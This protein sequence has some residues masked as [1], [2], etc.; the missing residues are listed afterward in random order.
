MGRL[1]ARDIAVKKHRGERIVALTAYDAPTARA[2]ESAGIDLILVGDSVGNVVLGMRD[3]R[4]V[5]LDMTIHHTAAVVRGTKTA[6]VCADLPFGSYQ[7]SPEEAKR[8]VVRVVAETGCQSVKLEGGYPWLETIR[9]IVAMGVPVLGHLGHTPQS[10]SLAALQPDRREWTEEETEALVAE[11]RALESAGCFALVL[12]V[13]PRGAARRVT[14]ALRIP[15][16][17]IGAGPHC[18]GQILVVNDILGI[19]P[20]LPHA[21]R[22]AELGEAMERA[23]REY[24]GEVRDGSFPGPEHGFG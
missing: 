19:G 1:L 10:V 13:V 2:L 24:A 4:S 21:R 6:H 15:T 7:V 5:T 9:A 8:S 23:A 20:R 16:I 12:E 18:D 3:P 14:E 22:Y 11:A 17:G